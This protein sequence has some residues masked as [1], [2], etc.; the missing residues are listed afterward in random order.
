LHFPDGD[1]E[2]RVVLT[3]VKP[4]GVTYEWHFD[5]RASDGKQAG[6]GEFSRFVSANDLAAAPRLNA[7]FFGNGEQ[8][9]P[10]YTAITISRAT[11]RDVMANGNARYASTNLEDALGDVAS[12]AAGGLLSSR[13]TYRGQLSLASPTIDSIPVLLQG[14][15]T[16]LPS[17]HLHGAYSFQDQKLSE[18]YWVLSDSAHPL[19]LKTVMGNNVF[20]MIRIDFPAPPARR[21]ED[22]LERNCRLELPGVY[23]GFNSAV[24]EP[25]SEPALTGVAT[26]MQRHPDWSFTIEGHT[27]SIGSA[28][29]NAKLSAARAEAVRA[30]LV[31]RHGIA[32]SR[33]DTAGFGATRPRE[34]NST[35]EGRARNRR[36]ELARHC[37]GSSH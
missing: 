11:F 10:G 32:P 27:D 18:D 5:Q 7:V 15:R 24:L 29:S 36:V 22:E 14:Q 30:A 21:E 8:E 3:D 9:T 37:G 19:V 23:F 13:L 35:I 12:G 28:T 31:E 26:L 25:A 20:Q 2:N 34:P 4:E 17:V 33:L 16:K 1:R 6:Q